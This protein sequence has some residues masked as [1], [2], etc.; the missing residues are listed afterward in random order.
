[1]RSMPYSHGI[2]GHGIVDGW[3]LGVLEHS[4]LCASSPFSPPRARFPH[5]WLGADKRQ[6]LLISCPFVFTGEI[7][8]LS[9]NIYV[10]RYAMGFRV[11]NT[12]QFYLYGPPQEQPN[13]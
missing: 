10:W 5:T 13:A 3:F 2:V 1:M 11:V 8:G 7:P 9:W 12:K 4:Y 6:E